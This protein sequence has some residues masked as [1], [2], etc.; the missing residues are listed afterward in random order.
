MLRASFDEHIVILVSALSGMAALVAAVGGVGLASTMGVN[1]LERT[2]E[3][4]VMQ[5]VGATPRDVLGIVV[6]EGVL[7]GALSWLLA[8]VLSLPLSA[9]VGFVAGRVGLGVPL[10][11]AVSPPAMLLW[12]GIVVVFAAAASF[13]PAWGASRMTVRETLAYE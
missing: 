11:F 10:D 5:A 13:Y 8:L 6:A 7:I 9:G 12:L 4:G 2:R 1:V 3:L